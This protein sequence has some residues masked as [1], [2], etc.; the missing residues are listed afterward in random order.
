VAS[1]VKPKQLVVKFLGCKFQE[2]DLGSR[3]QRGGWI[4]DH[5]SDQARLG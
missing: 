3:L 2:F 5:L 1:Q 4:V